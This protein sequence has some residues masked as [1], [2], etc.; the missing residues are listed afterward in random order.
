V[1]ASAVVSHAS[2]QPKPP[3]KLD[4]AVLQK[5]VGE[6]TAEDE[7][8]FTDAAEATMERVCIACHPFEKI[9]KTRHTVREWQ[10]QVTLM[11]GRGAPGTD[12]DFDLVKKYLPRYYGAVAVNT[13][14]A[15]ELTSVLGLSA[16]DAAAVVAY[17]MAHGS[18]TDLAS[19][20][21]VEGIDKAKLEAQ[22]E[23]LRFK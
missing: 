11:K 12:A 9:V 3:A 7:D 20:E 15:D 6:M 23:A 8:A 19:L 13:A 22:P 4:P 18:F 17:R 14:A 16:R 1:L 2:Q 5:S 10:E 21:K